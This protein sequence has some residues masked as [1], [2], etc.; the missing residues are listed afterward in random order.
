MNQVADTDA[1]Y[2]DDA[3]SDEID[4][5]FLDDSADDTK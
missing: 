2:S 5:S 4:M 3:K 1:Y